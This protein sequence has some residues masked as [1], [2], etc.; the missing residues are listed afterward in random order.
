M[1]YRHGFFHGAVAMRSAGLML[2][3]LVAFVLCVAAPA[4]Q[5]GPLPPPK[6]DAP[7][8]AASA[9]PAAAPVK[10]QESQRTT[11]PAGSGVTNQAPDVPVE[12]IVQTFAVREEEFKRERDNYTYTQTFSIQTLDVDGRPDGEYRMVSDIIFT[13]DGKR[14]EKVTYA[15][16]SSL[17]RILLTQEDLDDLVHV[18]P[19]VLTTEQLPKY[20]I[21]YVGRE[22]VDE[23][24]T[25]VF[26][27]KPKKLEKGQRYFDGKIWVDDKD[28]Q[29][30]KT[31][32]QAVGLKKKNE[33]SAFPHFETFRENIEG[34]YWFPTY[35]RAN[36]VL[37]FKTQDVPIRMFVK[38][39]N[40]KR[41]GST[42]KLG[43]ATEVKPQQ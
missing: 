3:L 36:D 13:P 5:T 6:P 30:V 39:E 2:A 15:P 28:L 18:Q 1:V 27:V 33:D 38:Y 23:L 35:T 9:T 19:F 26:D 34:H 7:S 31:Y 41:F 24:S 32:G 42:I 25:Y 22:Q 16:Q 20:D 29:I 10:Q 8:V 4:Q 14:V 43:Q 11:A 17:E 40:Y 37:H 12:Q 21:A